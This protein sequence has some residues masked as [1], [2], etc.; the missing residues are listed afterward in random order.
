MNEPLAPETILARVET[1]LSDRFEVLVAEVRR[2]GRAGIAAQAAAEACSEAIASLREEVT[3]SQERPPASETGEASAENVVRAILP[4]SDALD[5]IEKQ[6]RD[7]VQRVDRTPQPVA[8]HRSLLARL[9]GTPRQ[10][11]TEW[12]APP[13]LAAA[14]ALA[15]GIGVLRS[16]LE[17]ALRSVDV[18]FDRRTDVPVDSEAHRVVEVR[19]LPTND[20]VGQVAEVV[21]PGCRLGPKRIREAEVV[22]FVSDSPSTSAKGSSPFSDG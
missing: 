5:R 2:Q 15:Q 12:L 10:E 8:R 6:A 16:Q 17:E 3:A 22:V 18:T 4:V 13:V 21:R 14:R 11:Q 9:R 19:P 20:R 1:L 7:W